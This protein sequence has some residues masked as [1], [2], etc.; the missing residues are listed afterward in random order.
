MSLTKHQF[1]NDIVKVPNL[2]CLYRLFAIIFCVI[3]FL[4]GF[5]VG[6][7][8]IGF[9]AGIT[10]YMDGIY[11]RKHNMVTRLGALL[12]SVADLMFNF[13]V[14]AA[15]VYMEVW[16]LFVLFLWGFRDLTVLSMRASAAQLGFDIPSSYLGKVASNFIFY[17]LFLMPLDYALNS[18][19]YM[20]HDFVAANF[21]PWTGVGLHWFALCGLLIGIAMQWIAAF[22]YGRVYI[23]QYEERRHHRRGY[24]RRLPHRRVR[25]DRKLRSFGTGAIYFKR[26]Y[27]CADE[28]VSTIGRYYDEMSHLYSSIRVRRRPRKIH[29]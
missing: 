17:A 20:F 16:P 15:G 25:D 8:L 12:D 18:P 7:S 9:T 24:A 1:F 13:F 4:S 14:I 19:N 2:L 28:L 10:D 26:R 27:F 29:R 21:H 11:A 5:A 22:Q 6:S 3:L 23:R